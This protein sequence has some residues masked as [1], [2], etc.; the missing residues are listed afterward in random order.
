MLSDRPPIMVRAYQGK[1]ADAIALFQQDAAHMAQGGYY[2]VAQSYAPGSWGAGAYILGLLA[3]LLFGLG[4]LILG[5]MIIVKPAG[6]M[7][8][9]Y[10]LRGA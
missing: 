1:Q 6:T 4:L 10:Q 3:I 7:T 9:T 5:Y 2:P 8:V